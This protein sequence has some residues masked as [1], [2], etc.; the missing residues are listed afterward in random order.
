MAI[1]VVV[2][3]ILIS[4]KRQL[5]LIPHIKVRTMTQGMFHPFRSFRAIKEQGLGSLLIAG[6]MTAL[7]FLSS[8]AAT[9][10]S[11]FRY[12]DYDTETY[13]ALFQLLRT[14]GLILLWSVANW[15][16]STLMEG[17]GRLKEVFIVTSYSTLPV[18]LYNVLSIPLTHLVSSSNSALIAGFETVS[19][20]F[21]GIMLC[22]GLMITHDFSFPRFL[23]SAVV[24]VLFM[25]LGIFVLFMFAILL[26]Q[27]WSFLANAVLELIRW[28]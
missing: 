7:F 21:V 16:V 5:V 20:L 8:A 6:I 3:L 1:A 2:A 18:I 24:T 22:I 25:I 4:V 17:K 11:D 10:W 26:S 28:Q 14:V 19:L 15:A 27:F 9:I 13:N 12:T 23:F